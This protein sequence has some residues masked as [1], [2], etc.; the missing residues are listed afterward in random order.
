MTMM[1]TAQ[2]KKQPRIFRG[3]FFCITNL[4]KLLANIYIYAY[5][6]FDEQHFH[7]PYFH[8]RLVVLTHHTFFM[9]GRL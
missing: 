8:H 4:D 9:A 3:F 6:K 7:F 5:D 1:K 2:N